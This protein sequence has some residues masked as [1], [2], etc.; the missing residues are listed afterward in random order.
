MCDFGLAKSKSVGEDTSN[1]MTQ[2]VGTPLWMAPEVVT[3]NRYGPECDV[4]SFAIIMNEVLTEKKPY[5]DRPNSPP[6][7]IQVSTNPNFRPTTPNPEDDP[8][9]LPLKTMQSQKEYIEL[10]KRCWAHIPSERPTF[11]DV[12]DKLR[13][14]ASI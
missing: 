14:I 12:V 2:A 10:M 9:D 7:F 13:E 1:Q 8:S 11:A 6:I 5:F 4:F 3:G